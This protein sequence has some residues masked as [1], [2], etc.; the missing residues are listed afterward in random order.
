MKLDHLIYGTF[1]DLPGSQQVVYKSSGI[2]TDLES[3][4]IQQYDQFGDC[5]TEDFRSSLTLQWYRETES[6]VAVL[7]KVTHAGQDFSGRWGALLRHSA[8][9]AP[10]QKQSL[11]YDVAPVAA[12]QVST[13]SSEALAQSGDLEIEVPNSPDYLVDEVLALNLEHY[14]SNLKRLLCGERLVLYAD[15]NTAHLNR[16]LRNLLLL[17]PLQIRASLNWSEFVFHSLETLDL[18]IVH[19]SRYAA[20]EGDT[21]E[22]QSDG[23]NTLGDLSISGEAADEYIATLAQQVEE[24]NREKLAALFTQVEIVD[25]PESAAD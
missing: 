10:E 25:Q 21:I 14:R 15:L 22:F 20:P 18:S 19:S 24:S 17:M 4:L 8:I 3:W 9:L 6:P 13:G 23:D 12:Q 1:P 11:Y 2:S 16:Y 5:K 7:T